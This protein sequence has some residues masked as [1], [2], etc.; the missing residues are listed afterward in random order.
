MVYDTTRDRVLLFGGQAYH[1]W[2]MDLQDVWTYDVAARQWHYAGELE[3]GQVYAA[4]YD[5]RSDRAI[6]I[7]LRGETWA[8]CPGP[9]RWEKKNP[10]EAPSGRCGHKMVYDEHS[11]RVILFGGFKCTSLDDPLLGDTWAYDYQRDRWT[12]MEP[13]ASP[14]PR[15]YHGMV[16]H[17]AAGRTLV[18]G[19]RPHADREE[20]NLWAYDYAANTWVSLAPAAGPAC[21]LAYPTLVY[22]PVSTRVIM[23]GGIALTSDFQGRLNDEIWLY[24]M[25]AN[26]WTQQEPAQGP[27][28]RSHH[29][30]VFCDSLGKALLFGG[31]VGAA[32]SDQLVNDTWLYDPVS[33]SWADVTP[34]DATS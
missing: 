18:W 25:E 31:E 30:M 1:H 14:P 3:A 17:P 21:R 28:A 32:Y 26:A 20:A 27:E 12:R 7:N 2:G 6:M 5:R 24:D 34:P 10:P 23:F 11:N 19:G 33:H 16:Y 4:A 8:Y 22:D 29:A 15:I 9:N 13:Q